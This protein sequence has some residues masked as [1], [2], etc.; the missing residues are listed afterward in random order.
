MGECDNP[1]IAG[2]RP[3][4]EANAE[5]AQANA[6]WEIINGE[7]A[8][9][10]HGPTG[11]PNMD[12]VGMPTP[13]PSPRDFDTRPVGSGDKFNPYDDRRAWTSLF[14]QERQRV[15]PYT[16]PGG[17]L[18]ELSP[19][20]D[21]AAL[22][23]DRASEARKAIAVISLLPIGK[24]AKLGKLG[25]EALKGAEAIEGI[26]LRGGEA[27]AREMHAHHIFVQA[28]EF[29]E[30]WKATGINIED[31]RVQLSPGTHLGQLHSSAGIPGVGPGGLWNETWRQYFAA[32][33][34]AGRSITQEGVFTQAAQMLSDFGVPYY[35][36]LP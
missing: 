16:Q 19:Y 18:W 22:M 29:A 21:I 7:G 33:A 14:G 25:G 15:N 30:Q 4:A 26:A 11:N 10:M 12:L 6:L 23:S 2:E 20:S 1:S 8:E 27:A 17:F 9:S 34:A 32:E 3:F 31:F 35:S 5:E 13:D 24:I 36:P 28:E